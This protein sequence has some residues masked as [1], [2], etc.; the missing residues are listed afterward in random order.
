MKPTGKLKL[1]SQLIDLPLVDKD[2]RWCGVVD[3]IELVGRAGGPMR[4]K[5]LLA[6]P[7]AYGGR[8][9]KWLYW[10]I[11]M[12]AGNRV[13]RIP[14]SEIDSIRSAVHLKCKAEKLGLHVTEDKVRSWIPHGGAL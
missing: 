9:P 11:E 14:L 10:F 8:L 13:S 4:V 3:D 6:G 1:V 2:G 7:G 12:V 5:A